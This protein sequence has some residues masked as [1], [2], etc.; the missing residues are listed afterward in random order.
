MRKSAF[1]VYVFVRVSFGSVL[2]FMTACLLMCVILFQW[3]E[4]VCVCVCVCVEITSAF[5]SLLCRLGK[6]FGPV[7]FIRSPVIKRPK[8]DVPKYIYLYISIYIDIYF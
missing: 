7:I 4:S 8:P 5:F 2:T 1:Q 3:I 6:T